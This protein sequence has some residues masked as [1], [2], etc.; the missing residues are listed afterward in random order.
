MRFIA[1]QR[2]GIDEDARCFE[3]CITEIFSCKERDLKELS[4]QLTSDANPPRTD[5]SEA[6][7]FLRARGGA[8]KHRERHLLDGRMEAFLKHLLGDLLLFLAGQLAS[9][10]G[11]EEAV[12]Q[13]GIR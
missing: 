8:M 7:E 2:E 5:G 4:C 13:G 9:L 6:L 12:E 11:A 1:K 3:A 10:E